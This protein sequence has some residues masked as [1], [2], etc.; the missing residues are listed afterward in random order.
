MCLHRMCHVFWHM[1]KSEQ[2]GDIAGIS[3]IEDAD[4]AGFLESFLTKYDFWLPHL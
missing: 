2:A 1:N 3:D 4:P